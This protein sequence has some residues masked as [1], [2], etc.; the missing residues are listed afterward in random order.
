MRVLRIALGGLLGG[1]VVHIAAI[2]MF[3]GL[4]GGDVWAATEAYGPE[5]RFVVL[6]QPE[7]GGPA[8]PYLD[9]G[10]VHA[11]CR[12]RLDAGPVNV[13][14]NVNAEFWSA[15]IYDRHGVN[16]YSL[17]DQT[18]GRAPLD[19]LIIGPD[20]LTELQRAEAPI[21]E[22]SVVVDLTID[23][24]LILI[25]AF[26]EDAAMIAPLG[27]MLAMAE[28]GSLGPSGGDGAAGPV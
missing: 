9:P 25:R 3:P 27:A 21:L 12:F 26:F 28:C 15:S 18:A 14:A 22:R 10:F 7:P 20:D 13:I 5:G 19:L 11:L 2:L 6:P 23:A 24:G 8:T 17:N 16:L 4:G 1:V